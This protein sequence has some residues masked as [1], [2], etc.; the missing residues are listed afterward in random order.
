[1]AKMQ[2]KTFTQPDEKRKFDKGLLELITLGTA[3]NGRAKTEAP[4]I[5][6]LRELPPDLLADLVAESERAGYRFV[7]RLVAEWVSGANRFDRSGEA[8][9]AVF[10]GGQVAGVCGLNADP[11]TAEPHV[12][13]VRHLYVREAH[14]RSGVGRRLI[15]AVIEAARGVFGR[16]H[17]RTTNTQSA[18]FFE[19]LGFRPCAGRPDCTHLLELQ[20]DR[21]SPL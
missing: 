15:T 18:R 10:V 5:T 7:R 9:F 11:Y 3:L 1:M 17:L 4:V 13:R 12:G 19:N 8:L 21:N 16:L 6:R 14:R 2:K 20:G